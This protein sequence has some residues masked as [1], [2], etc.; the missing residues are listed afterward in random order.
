MSGGALNVGNP[1][2]P[3][4]VSLGSPDGQ[5][6]LELTKTQE[7]IASI[8]V[9]LG[10]SAWDTPDPLTK[11][12]DGNLDKLV[13]HLPNG[14]TLAFHSNRTIASDGKPFDGSCIELH[15]SAGKPFTVQIKDGKLWVPAESGPTLGNDGQSVSFE[16]GS[17]TRIEVALKNA[18]ELS[19]TASGGSDKTT[20]SETTIITQ[21]RGSRGDAINNVKVSKLNPGKGNPLDQFGFPPAILAVYGRTLNNAEKGQF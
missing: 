4:V 15:T 9:K 8:D 17:G 11:A 21:W 16:N 6:G 12:I 1:I 5:G 2:L 7:G 20:W 13:E 18:S 19:I 10:V 3:N 14:G